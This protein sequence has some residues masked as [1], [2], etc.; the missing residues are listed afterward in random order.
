MRTLEEDYLQ[1]KG[2]WPAMTR[3]FTAC[4][5]FLTARRHQPFFLDVCYYDINC[6]QLLEN[7]RF[8]L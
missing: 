1:V 7:R 2:S 3:T 4:L 8:Y 6:D 5:D